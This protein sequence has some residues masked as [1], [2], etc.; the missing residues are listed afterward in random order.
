[1]VN[2]L[3]V[4]T[5][6]A[7]LLMLFFAA[8]SVAALTD[9]PVEDIHFRAEHL[10]EAAQ[11]ARYATLPL[12][13][14]GLRADRWQPAVQLGIARPDGEFAEAAGEMFAIGLARAWGNN[15]ALGVLGFYDRFDVDGS[16]YE[17]ALTPGS[18][19][20][21]PLDI[22]ERAQF[23]RPAGAIRHS[24]VGVVVTRDHLDDDSRRWGYVGGL[25]LERLVLADY[26]FHY[27]LLAGADAG[28]EGDI[29]HSGANN[30][31]TVFFGVQA[32]QPLTPRLALTPH[33]MIGAPLGPGEFTTGLT[34]PGFDVTTASSGASP[35]HI[36]DAF[37]SLGM[38]LR[39]PVTGLEFDLGA[40]LLFPIYQ[41]YIHE[42][43]NN[44]LLL[45]VSWHGH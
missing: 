36:G 28:A 5:L 19:T 10:A 43:I 20:G 17:N 8:A 18:L 40:A 13:D 41:R 21:V 30:L 23:T 25:L 7:A 16:A 4:R 38:G 39:D 6:P 3:V 33:L 26:R 9:P 2:M 1:M 42:G 45:S 44:S 24:G 11:E 29:D 12:P 35:G 22:P 32:Q 31:V 27:R 34:G 15:G 37:L 14:V